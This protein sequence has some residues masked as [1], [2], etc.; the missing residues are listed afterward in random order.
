MAPFDNSL[1][2]LKDIL[3][4]LALGFGFGVALDRAG[5]NRYHKI[6]NV[7]RFT[8]L[9]VLKFMLS[10]LVTGMVGIY[11]LHWAG[12]IELSTNVSL[13]PLKALTGG[14]LFGIGMALIGMCPGTAVAGAAR[15]QLDYLIPG[16]GGMLTGALVYGLL[17]PRINAVFADLTNFGPAKL[18]ELWHLAPALTVFVFAQ[19]FLLVLY[20]AA[21]TGWHRRD[22]L[23]EDAQ[24]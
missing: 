23:A 14:L 20:L 13:I 19:G 10:A 16:I 24:R 12:E 9:A 15:G 2:E 5:M 6:V 4:A 3:I 22:A 1:W 11:A 18:P 7:Y 17:S 8:D 21:R